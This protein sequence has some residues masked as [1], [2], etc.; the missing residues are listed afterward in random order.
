MHNDEEKNI[1][2]SVLIISRT[3]GQTMQK[4]GTPRNAVTVGA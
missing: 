2:K 3:P 4:N 1:H